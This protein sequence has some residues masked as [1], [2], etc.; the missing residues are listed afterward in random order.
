MAAHAVTDEPAVIYGSRGLSPVN[1]IISARAQITGIESPVSFSPG[2]T[3]DEISIQNTLKFT[4][5]LYN[6]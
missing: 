6:E 2:V 3:E 1:E 4:D 5:V